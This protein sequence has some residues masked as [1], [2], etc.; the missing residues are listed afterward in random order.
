MVPVEASVSGVIGS[1]PNAV[2]DERLKTVRDRYTK[3]MDYLKSPD[4]SPG[5]NGRSK[6]ETYVMKQ[7]LWSREVEKYTRAQNDALATVKPAPGASPKAVKEARE[8]YMQ[9]VQEHGR[10]VLLHRATIVR[11]KVLNWEERN[12]KPTAAEIRAEIRRLRNLLASHEVL[13]KGVEE[14]TF[15][16]VI[17]DQNGNGD[18]DL[19]RAY[20]NVYDDIDKKSNANIK[21]TRPDETSRAKFLDLYKPSAQ[22]PLQAVDA[23]GGNVLK[24]LNPFQKLVEEQA[25]WT[26]TSLDRNRATARSDNEKHMEAAQDWL[27]TKIARLTKDIEMLEKELGG[28]SGRPMLMSVVDEK[29]VAITDD[30]TKADPALVGRPVPANEWTRAMSSMS[31]L[32]VEITMDCMVVEID[33]PWLHAELFNDA[34]LDSGKFDISPGAAELKRL[35]EQDQTP[36]GPHQQFSSYPTAFVVAADVQLS[37]S[38]DTTQL[39]SAV[40]ASS[41][42]ANLSV[43]YGP[44]N[45]SGSH[46]QSKSSSK[47]K[48]E[49]T[50]TG[51]R[52]SIQAPQIVAWVQTLMPQL[53]KPTNGASSMVGLFAK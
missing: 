37:F 5:A 8:L 44:F 23:L 48:M 20:A 11:D 15:F 41:S 53:P 36:S 21:G 13:L 9:W 25:K 19:R 7:E 43:G 47:T 52:I 2:T 33:R 28:G 30:D 49:S 17:A 50:A 12:N 10:D 46:K 42:E 34:E 26:E 4:D 51:C 3:A 39:E 45:I 24:N 22:D 16:P 29:G 6:L 35:Y 14:K 18:S 32:E 27:K 1:E 31:N 38:G 40:S